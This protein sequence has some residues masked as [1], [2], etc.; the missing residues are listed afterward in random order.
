MM[1]WLTV[2][3]DNGRI[4]GKP[5]NFKKRKHLRAAVSHKSCFLK[6]IIARLT[7]Y[8]SANNFFS[9]K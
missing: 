1:I 6:A 2:N 4:I 7:L 8:Y 5:A 3:V 9:R